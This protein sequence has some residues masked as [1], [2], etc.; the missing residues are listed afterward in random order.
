MAVA[1]TAVFLAGL[2]F[3]AGAAPAPRV[4]AEAVVGTVFARVGDGAAGL[5]AGAFAAGTAFA[6]GAFVAATFFAGTFV[7]GIFAGAGL[8][9]LTDPAADLPGTAFVGVAGGRAFELLGAIGAAGAVGRAGAFGAA[10]GAFDAGAFVGRAAFVGAT[11]DA[12][13]AFGAGAA[14]VGA[15][16]VGSTFGATGT[17]GAGAAVVG[18]TFVGATFD[19]AGAFVG[20]ARLPAGAAA[21]SIGA[22]RSAP[23]ATLSAANVPTMSSEPVRAGMRLP[24]AFARRPA[25][26]LSVAVGFAVGDVLISGSAVASLRLRLAG[27]RSPA[28]GSATGMA[29]VGAISGVARSIPRRDGLKLATTKRRVSP[30]LTTSRAARGAGSA[31]SRSGT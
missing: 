16:F 18:A 28:T 20:R 2:A 14:F 24:A 10:T 12:T 1:F 19:A 13:G 15:T 29:T 27:A 8:V 11:F 7:A 17:F 26:G 5:L 25:V 30:S 22:P 6:A 23:A 9:V 31:I 21:G 4:P 3:F